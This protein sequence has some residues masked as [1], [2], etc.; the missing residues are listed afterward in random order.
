MVA[1]EMLNLVVIFYFGDAQRLEFFNIVQFGE[2]IFGDEKIRGIN[3][4]FV[5]ILLISEQDSQVVVDVSHL[6]EITLNSPVDV[7]VR[8]IMGTS[9]REVVHLAQLPVPVHLVIVHHV[10]V[11]GCEKDAGE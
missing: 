5:A 9:C 7:A 4:Q 3:L 11:T 10:Q 2:F 8:H 6:K 1:A